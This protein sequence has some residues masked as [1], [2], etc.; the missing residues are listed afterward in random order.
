MSKGPEISEGLKQWLQ[1]SDQL[2]ATVHRRLNV[3]EHKYAKN[4]R[5]DEQSEQAA[6]VKMGEYNREIE[7]IC[8]RME[9]LEDGFGVPS[10]LRGE[11]LTTPLRCAVSLLAKSRLGNS[12][13]LEYLGDLAQLAGGDCPA[14]ALAIRDAFMRDGCL[15]FA[16]KLDSK[17]GSG[18]F[19]Q[20]TISMRERAFQAL[21]GRDWC[22]EEFD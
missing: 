4:A 7:K 5:N 16:V 12:H 3:R 22:D 21:L 6:K 13:C 8:R 17:F 20:K 15:R 11:T 10:L 19:D 9:A 1:L 18:A 14:D 2:V